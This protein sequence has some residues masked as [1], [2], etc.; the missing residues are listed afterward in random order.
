MT[1]GWLCSLMHNYGVTFD[2]AGGVACVRAVVGYI[3]ENSFD[4][5]NGVMGGEGEREGVEDRA[6]MKSVA[7]VDRDGVAMY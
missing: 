4:A 6:G 1:G 7:D 5:E 2:D 3:V